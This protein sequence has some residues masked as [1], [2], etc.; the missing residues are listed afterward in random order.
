[1]GGIAGGIVTSEAVG[2]FGFFP[3]MLVGGTLGLSIFPT[4]AGST[5]HAIQVAYTENVS[6]PTD[7]SRYREAYI[8]KSR[9]LRM[10]SA[11]NGT[12]LTMITGAMGLVL[13]I[14]AF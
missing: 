12:A 10:R 8:K 1:M 2:G 14:S 5:A 4:L 7:Q 6:T 9:Q 11:W 3:G 13:L